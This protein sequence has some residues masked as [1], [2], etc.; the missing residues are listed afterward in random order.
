[1]IVVDPLI[2]A[3]NGLSINILVVEA[4]KPEF[5]SQLAAL[6]TLTNVKVLLAVAPVSSAIP[7]LMSKS[8]PEVTL[9]AVY[10]TPLNE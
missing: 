2:S 6:V 10:C 1:M 3:V 9:F 7:E 8:V 4:V 5:L